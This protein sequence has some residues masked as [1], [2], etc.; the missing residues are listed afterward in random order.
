MKI[1]IE[2]IAIK[3][4]TPADLS[5]IITVHKKAFGYDKEAELTAALLA[6]SSAEPMLS[7]LARHNGVAVGHVLFTKTGFDNYTDSPLMHILAPLAVMPE[8]QR[9]GIGGLLIIEGLEKLRVM[10]SQMVFVLG[11]KEYYPRYGFKPHAMH[12]GYQA[13]Y[14]I[15]EKNSAYWMYQ[16]L[17]TTAVSPG[18]GRLACADTLNRPE[19]WRDDETDR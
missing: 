12:A 11:H 15:P 16:A 10:G 18:S 5:D 4:T 8:Y 6:D 14:P 19:H 13:P 9:R 1:I 3:T 2:N 7:L 17:S